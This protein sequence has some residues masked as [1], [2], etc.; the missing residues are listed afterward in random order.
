MLWRWCPTACWILSAPPGG[1]DEAATGSAWAA[2]TT[3]APLAPLAAEHRLAPPLG[4]AHDCQR[5]WRPRPE[6][7]DAAAPDHHPS[8]SWL[9]FPVTA[10]DRPSPPLGSINRQNDLHL[11]GILPRNVSAMVAPGSG[12]D[13]MRPLF[14]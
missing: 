7:W 12:L 8:R 6:E 2:A 9:L 14:P 4:L 10:R 11:W 13:I 5:R 3:I 1:L